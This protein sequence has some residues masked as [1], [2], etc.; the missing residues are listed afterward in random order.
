MIHE[1]LK[2]LADAKVAKPMQIEWCGEYDNEEIVESVFNVIDAI[3]V[4]SIWLENSPLVIHEALEA[5]VLVITADAGGMAE[6]VHHE[7][8]GLLFEHRK[9]LA[10]AEQMARC[11]DKDLVQRLARRGYLR[12]AWCRSTTVIFWPTWKPCVLISISHK[13]RERPVRSVP[14]VESKAVLSK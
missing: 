13:F 3:V 5:G 9:P 10:L 6:Y 14:F 12:L 11:K 2:R 1:A 8:N 7:V 4:P